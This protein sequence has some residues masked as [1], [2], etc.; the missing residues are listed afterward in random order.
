MPVDKQ[1]VICGRQLHRYAYHNVTCSRECGAEMRKRGGP[2]RFWNRVDTS[3]GP[4]ACWPFMGAHTSDGYGWLSFDGEYKGAHVVAFFLANGFWPKHT[5]HTCDNPPCCNPKHL[6]DGT[7]QENQMDAVIRGRQPV[8]ERSRRAKLSNED[9]T[10]IRSRY[11][12]GENPAKIARDF[13][14]VTY[15]QVWVVA[16]RHKGRVH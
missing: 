6:I 10:L 8:G 7:M 4:D 11:D 13:P 16:T 15:Q 5:R 2:K 9:V 14:Q 12:A 3:G 1:C